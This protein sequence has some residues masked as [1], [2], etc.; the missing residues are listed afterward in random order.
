MP[1]VERVERRRRLIPRARLVRIDGRRRRCTVPRG[2]SERVGRAPRDGHRGVRDRGIPGV[3]IL[4]LHTALTEQQQAAADE[5]AQHRHPTL[6][7]DGECGARE[8]HQLR[9]V[10]QLDQHGGPGLLARARQSIRGRVEPIADDDAAGV[11]RGVEVVVSPLPRARAHRRRVAAAEVEHAFVAGWRA[12]TGAA[13]GCQPL[14]RLPHLLGAPRVDG[15]ASPLGIALVEHVRKRRGGEPE[16]VTIGRV[17]VGRRRVRRVLR[18]EALALLVAKVLLKAGRAVALDDEAPRRKIVEC[19]PAAADGERRELA[20]GAQA[21][22]AGN[23]LVELVAELCRRHRQ[24][25]APVRRSRLAVH[26]QK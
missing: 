9:D 22:C 8:Q 23:V 21:V 7:A 19:V 11:A 13:R 17:R 14:A 5:P 10:G 15:R 26:A 3:V 1:S 24:V 16:G 4:A 25:L 20:G 6:D 18:G 2:Q 12:I